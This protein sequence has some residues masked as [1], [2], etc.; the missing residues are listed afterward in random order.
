MPLYVTD[1]GQQVS[2]HSMLKTF[3]RCPKQADYKY[4]QRLKPKLLGTPL[5][6]GSW[7]HLL[8]E[9]KMKGGDWRALHKKLTAKFG[10]LLDEEKDYYGD[11]PNECYVLML[12]YEW[13]YEYDPWTVLETEFTIETEFPD[14]TLYRGRVDALIENHLGI[15]VVDHKSHKTLPNIDFR[16]RDAQSALY[17]W[18]A[19]R[20]RIP[21]QGFIWNYIR[22]KA[23]SIPQLTQAGRLSRRRID[24][25]YPTFVRALKRYKRENGLVITEAHREFANHL[26]EAQYR[27]GKL[28]TSSFFRRDILEKSPDMLRRIARE[29]YHTSKRMHAY[30]FDQTDIVERVVDRSCEFACSYNHLCNMELMGGD[31]RYLRRQHFTIGDPMDYYEDRAGDA[32]AGLKEDN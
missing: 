5:K 1:E 17:L 28:Q 20:N 24:T 4:H 7:L 30:P 10:E 23:P 25:D 12:S 31:T 3:R 16:L 32:P 2:T 14:G 9:E 15:W 18:C 13:H 19:A 26:R 29:N 21:V 6:R 22:T 11:L 8:L 27:P